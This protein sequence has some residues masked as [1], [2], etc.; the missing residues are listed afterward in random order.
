[1]LTADVPRP[2][3]KG[4]NSF[5]VISEC[6]VIIVL[7][8]QTCKDLLRTHVPTLI[9]LAVSVL[10]FNARLPPNAPKPAK[11]LYHELITCQVRLP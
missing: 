7:F 3:V 9:P 5:R 6:P 8:F 10:S 11:E 2:A 1:M 4:I